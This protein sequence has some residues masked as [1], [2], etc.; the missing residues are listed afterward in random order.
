MSGSPRPTFLLEVGTEEIPDRML[1]SGEDGLRRELEVALRDLGIVTP[2]TVWLS[3]S[4]PRRLAVSAGPMM[5]RQADRE[6][7]V[8]GPPVRAA[9]DAAGNPTRAAEGFAKSQGV[10][11][12]ALQ[13]V[14]TDRGEYVG[15]QK[16]VT[17]RP[18]AE[19]LAEAV[20]PV[21]VRLR[22]PKMMRWGAVDFRF[23]R[24]IRWIVAL[25]G[26]EVVPLQVAG[27]S[28]GRDSM[29][30][31]TRSSGAV[32]ISSPDLYVEELRGAGVTVD[33]AER[34]TAIRAGLEKAAAGLE[35]VL[36]PDEALLESVVNMTEAPGV[37]AGSF[38]PEF[39]DLPREVLVTAMRHHQ[40]YFSLSTS[41]SAATEDPELLPSFLAVINQTDDPSGQIRRGNEWVLRARLADAR[42]FWG[43][44]RKR[45]LESRLE[46]LERVIFQ[47]K[48]GS[49]R[50]KVDRVVGLV[51]GLGQLAGLDAAI[52]SRA[53]QAA[54][55][56]KCDLTTEMVGEFPELQGIMGGIYARADSEPDEIARAIYQQYRP[57]GPGD[58]LPA[59]A[60]GLLVALADRVDTLTG[61]FGIGAEPTGTRDPFALRRAGTAVVRILMECGWAVSLREA[62]QRS[63]AQFHG[64]T[65][66]QA[67]LLPTL[68]EFF[69]ERA[70]TVA[71]A[72]GHRYDSVNAVFAAEF[73]DL[74][75]T[76][77]RLEAL[78]RLRADPSHEEA[79]DSLSIAFKRIRNLVDG[80]E[81]SSVDAKHLTEVPEVELHR[82]LVT[83]ASEVERQ[84]V[85][86]DYLEAFRAIASLR[87]A[88]DAF[89]GSSRSEGVLVMAP[90][91]AVRANRLAL[92]QDVGDLFSRI[93]DFSEIVV[94]G[95][96]SGAMQEARP[97][98]RHRA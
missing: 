20:E 63:I 55:L 33:P 91:L 87:V 25:L 7:E 45:S 83:V 22:F 48:L 42:F 68:V 30:H 18:T 80:V 2:D 28:S 17:G 6:E 90:D 60:E 76:G 71:E 24:P 62:L 94:E 89:L 75:D 58:A 52:C 43:E 38:P 56:S 8:T 13:R 39:L 37:L 73:D 3:W 41:A 11:V 40:H 61:Y 36:L 29:G 95:A 74:Q 88:V 27:V 26:E 10:S 69:R 65:L 35:G 32:P 96:P 50:E 97:A 31:R 64:S 59:G 82:Q 1:A 15:I 93:A 85:R 16:V 78:T 79:F 9:F 54:R 44:D 53:A 49:Y 23:V 66:T 4:T 81:R 21:L 72:A 86:R 14:T 19:L 47:E 77:L 51:E 92:L 98:A 46:D 70:R 5:G 57:A 67:D 84:V 34:R 12:D